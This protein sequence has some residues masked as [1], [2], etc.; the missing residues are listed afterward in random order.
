MWVL[1]QRKTTLISMRHRQAGRSSVFQTWLLA[2]SNEKALFLL[3]LTQ[4]GLEE[5]GWL[6][7][8]KGSKWIPFSIEKPECWLGILLQ[9]DLQNNQLSCPWKEQR[10][11]AG[12]CQA[13]L[14][15]P[16]QWVTSS[17]QMSA[18]IQ[19]KK[20]VQICENVIPIWLFCVQDNGKI[21]P[22]KAKLKQLNLKCNKAPWVSEAQVSWDFDLSPGSDLSLEGSGKGGIEADTPQHRR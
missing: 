12:Q 10:G 11:R 2:K 22:E 13:V 19:E 9:D 4:G 8:H 15:H 21:I 20:M 6:W 7:T 14:S 1:E 17:K 3:T 16:Q 18:L 5:L